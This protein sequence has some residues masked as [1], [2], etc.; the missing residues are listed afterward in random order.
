[1]DDLR[2][3]P[4]GRRNAAEEELLQSELSGLEQRL[5]FNRETIQ[6]LGRNLESKQKELNHAKKELADANPKFS[7]RQRELQDLKESHKSI[8][9]SIAEVEDTVFANFC[10]GLGFDNIRSY[11]AQQ[12]SLQQ[13]GAQRKLEFKQQKSKLDNRKAFEQQQLQVVMERIQGLEGKMERDQSLIEELEEQK[14][15]IA[16][17]SDALSTELELL[18]EN[19]EEGQ[20]LLDKRAEKVAEQRREVQKRNKNVE[21]TMKEV[22]RLEVEIQRNATDRYALLKRCKLEDITVPLLPDSKGFDQL[23][24]DGMPQEEPSA[25]DIDDD[26]NGSAVILAGYHD[27]GIEVDF[28]D[29]DDDLKEVSYDPLPILT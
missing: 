22:S 5:S 20:G 6:N 26:T 18:K 1:M 2:G 13:E 21:G 29:L 24:L 25:M 16:N 23:P 3:L 12:G 7:Q 4:D 11:E 9:D 17:E 28:E 8:K 15:A 19:L 27:F 14:D 10:E